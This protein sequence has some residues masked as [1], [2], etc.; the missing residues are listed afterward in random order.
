MSEF[1]K[2]LEILGE[3]IELGESRTIDFNLVYSNLE[4]FHYCRIHQNIDCK[5]KLE[6]LIFHY[7]LR[8]IHKLIF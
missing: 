7:Y 4:I 6:L 2:T 3:K 1:V 8:L 5:K